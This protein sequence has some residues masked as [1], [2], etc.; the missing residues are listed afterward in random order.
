MTS[1]KGMKNEKNISYGLA[2][3]LYYAVITKC[4]DEI[5]SQVRPWFTLD[6]LFF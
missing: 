6:I 4:S 2:D 3:H 1:L 5:I